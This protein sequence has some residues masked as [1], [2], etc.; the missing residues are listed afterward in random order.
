MNGLSRIKEDLGNRT[1]VYEGLVS[2]DPG[3]SVWTFSMY[4]GMKLNGDP[5]GEEASLIGGLTQRR[6]GFDRFMKRVQQPPR[7]PIPA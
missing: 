2:A 1:L 3:L 5:S 4:G 6:P 7:Q